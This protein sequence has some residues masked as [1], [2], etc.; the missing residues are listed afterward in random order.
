VSA[1][2]AAS[3]SGPAITPFVLSFM[4]EQSGGRTRDVNRELIVSNARLAAE[5][6]VAYAGL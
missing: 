5:T 2:A 1:A 4:H 6:A 3:V